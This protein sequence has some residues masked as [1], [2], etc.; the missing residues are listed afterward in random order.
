MAL[1]YSAASNEGFRKGWRAGS[2]TC[3]DFGWIIIWDEVAA[4]ARFE[5]VDLL[6]LL[7]CRRRVVLFMAGQL[8]YYE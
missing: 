7:F 8:Q 1:R 2:A 4:A 3:V 5:V 6:A